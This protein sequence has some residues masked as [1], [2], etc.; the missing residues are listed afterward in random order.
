M[1]ENKLLPYAGSLL[2]RTALSTPVEHPKRPEVCEVDRQSHISS[3]QLQ[4]VCES[5]I[6]APVQQVSDLF[7]QGCTVHVCTQISCQGTT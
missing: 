7:G 2:P 4:E 6:R 3:Q 5:Q 1:N